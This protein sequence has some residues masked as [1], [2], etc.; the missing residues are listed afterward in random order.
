[1]DDTLFRVVIAVI[2]LVPLLVGAALLVAAA[3]S[4]AALRAMA[5]GQPLA[6]VVVDNQQHSWQ[7]G[8]LTFSPAVRFRDAGGVDRLVVTRDSSSHSWVPGTSVEVL[9]DDSRPDLVVLAGSRAASTRRF[10]SAVGLVAALF[11]VAF[12]VGVWTVFGSLVTGGSWWAGPLGH[13]A[14]A[15]S[16]LPFGS[17]DPSG[18]TGP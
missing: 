7:D 8:R 3:R 6:G 14:P 1:M 13:P 2:A 15:S 5:N 11:F 16:D 12:G 4:R 10:G 18:S 17:T 9:V